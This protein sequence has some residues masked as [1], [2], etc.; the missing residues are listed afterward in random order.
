MSD[1]FNPMGC[2][3]PGSCVQGISQA[4]RLEWVAISFSQGSSD[5]GIEPMFHA[6][7]E[8]SLLIS[9][10]AQGTGAGAGLGEGIVKGFGDGHTCI[11]IF[12]MDHQY[13]IQ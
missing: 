3:P 9:N 10:Q 8:H 2:S 11:A 4:R 5:P 7:Q 6:F 1:S 13:S 12:R